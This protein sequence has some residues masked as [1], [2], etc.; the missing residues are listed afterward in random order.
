[1]ATSIP[2]DLVERSGGR[3]VLLVM[4]GLGGLPDAASGL[5]ELET[6]ATPNL[7]RIARGASLGLHQ[8]AGPGVTPGSGPGHLALFGYDPI[9]FNIGRGVLSALGVGFDLQVGDLATRLNFATVDASGNVT[10][11]RAGRPADDENKRLVQKLQAGLK[12]PPGVELFFSSEK[13]HRLVLVLRAPGL[14][15]AL[16]DTDPQETGVPALPVRATEESSRKSAE[17]VQQVLDQAHQILKDEPTANAVLA[18]GFAAYGVYPSIA[19]R[20]GLRAR[21]LAR[22]PMYLGVARL[23]G[24]DTAPLAASDDALLAALSQG[25][26]DYDFHFIHFK[27]V[28]SRGEDGDF[29]AKV[30]AIEAIDALL[31]RIE[32]LKPD[33]LLV[34]GDHST[35]A[36]MRA[37]SWHPVPV[38]IASPWT[39]PSGADG[40]GERACLRGDLGIFPA[41]QLM[42]LALAHA[43]RLAK[44][45]A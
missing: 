25:F 39:R 44:F 21:A 13:E 37:H 24:M 34:T 26:T 8:P 22:Y 38:L 14:N 29:A 15:A 2:D 35:P 19:D 11:R 27:A 17:L 31:P 10:D 3:I 12:P 41:M 28:D 33:V 16:A 5:T 20:F 32:A 43:G 6:A 7:D 1:M 18:R 45:G 36:R 30:K 23:V 9:A 40:F 42:T 4:D